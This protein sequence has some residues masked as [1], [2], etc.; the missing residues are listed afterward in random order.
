[1]SAPDRVQLARQ[2]GHWTAAARRLGALDDHAAAAAW[3][4]LE[5]YLGVAVRSALAST[6]DTLVARGAGLRAALTRARTPAELEAVRR[7]LLDF[8]E[9]YLRAETTVDFYADAVNTRTNPRIAALLRACD[10]LAYRSMAMAFDPLRK[11][12]PSVL[13]YLDSGIGAAIL[14]AGLRLWDASTESPAAAIKIVRHSLL[15]P[16]SLIH[17]CGHQFAHQTGWNPQTAVALRRWLASVPDIR[18]V[19]T[20]WTSEITADA[21][22]F[23]HTGYAAVANL[24]DVLSGGERFVF[25]LPPGD[26]HPVGYL[27]VLLNT[28]MCRLAYGAGPWDAL[29]QTWRATHPLEACPDPE[30]RHLV[31]ASL[32]VLPIVAAV[33]LTEPL[34]AFGGRSLSALVP[35]ERVAPDALEALEKRLGPA[36]YTSM[37][38]L[39]MEGLRLLALSGW[40]AAT[41]PERAVEFAT[42][43]EAWMTRLGGGERAA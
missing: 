36:L 20:G 16:T 1:M 32:P 37:H 18:D 6:A 12:T 15:C 5:H 43:Q 14:K 42:E 2:I 40:K 3:S 41:Q 17:E 26:P 31:E 25:R 9:S 33:L 30:V 34:D 29:E 21:F 8:R 22:A 19:W 39:W 7:R 13:T 35:P 24:H 10:S 38:W 23:A 11:Q 4:S 28:A 27:R